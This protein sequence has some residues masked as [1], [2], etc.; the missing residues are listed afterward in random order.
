M[1]LISFFI[2]FKLS[3]KNEMILNFHEN[4]VI[5]TWVYKNPIN[6]MDFDNPKFW[7]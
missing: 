7:P 1:Q 3:Q 5:T 4:F 6:C 2:K